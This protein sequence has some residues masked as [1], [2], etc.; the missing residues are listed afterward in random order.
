MAYH[1]F[2]RDIEG[3]LCKNIIEY[4][5]KNR[6]TCALY[7]SDGYKIKI[8]KVPYYLHNRYIIYTVKS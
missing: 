1:S 7:S 5:E 6:P 3:D 4:M 2:R 8:N